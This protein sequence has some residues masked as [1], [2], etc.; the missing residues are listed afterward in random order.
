[1]T[2]QQ[3]FFI[4]HGEHELVLEFENDNESARVTERQVNEPFKFDSVP[5]ASSGLRSTGLQ[6]NTLLRLKSANSSDLIDDVKEIKEGI[7]VANLLQSEYALASH[8]NNEQ[9]LYKDFVYV[10][11]KE[12]LVSMVKDYRSNLDLTSQ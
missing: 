6:T 3:A 9:L 8:L 4:H 11:E 10:Q 12:K 2:E 5:K 1:L 7:V